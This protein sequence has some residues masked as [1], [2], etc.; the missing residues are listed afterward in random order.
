MP[1]FC[2]T[3][4][5]IWYSYLYL[6]AEDEDEAIN[7]A[8]MGIGEV[9]GSDF[10]DTIGYV[11]IRNEDTHE[12]TDLSGP[13]IDAMEENDPNSIFSKSKKQEEVDKAIITLRNPTVD[14]YTRITSALKI[15]GDIKNI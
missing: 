9:D 6:D 8:G 11:S 14:S 10:G 1:T 5:E 4:K 3:A 2:V 12:D 7:L 15:L 13:A